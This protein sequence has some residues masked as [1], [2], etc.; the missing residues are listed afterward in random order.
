VINLR[1]KP[2]APDALRL[3]HITTV[4]ETLSF[5]TGQVGY[6]QSQGFEVF[7]ISSPGARLQ[8]FAA[9]E[10]VTC[11]A[12]AMTRR[13]SPLDDLRSLLKM[14][15]ELRRIRPAI[16]HGHTPKGGL[17][18]MIAAWAAGV[19]VRIYHVH[20]LPLTT[21]TGLKRKLLC[22]T[23]R[24][25]CFFSHQVLCV[26]RSVRDVAIQER[27]CP[28]GKIKVLAQ[29]T[30]NGID[31]QQRFDPQRLGPDSGVQFRRHYGIPADARL[32]GFVGRIVRDKGLVELCA[33]WRELRQQFADVHLLIAGPFESQDPVPPD[34]EHTLR[35]DNRV[36]LPG[37]VADMPALYSAVDVILLPTYRE[38]F[39]YVP[40]EAA[41]MGIPVVATR[42]PGCMEAVEE[43]VT[44]TL[45][46]P[47]DAAALA[48][49]AR[50]YLADADLRR[51]HGAAGRQRMLREFQQET[52]WSAI[53]Q[54]Y[55]RWLGLRGLA[56]EIGRRATLL[57]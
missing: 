41:A 8:A 35:T 11:R 53:Y 55:R 42:V 48:E 30:I 7:A 18:G 5:L 21:A 31:A 3:V 4:P 16:V 39:P 19:P 28:P 27:L 15:R 20:G 25:S 57:V 17:L 12:V 46:A 26:S 47:R 40:L 45:V 13:I 14:W 9:Q 2:D 6:M 38:G 36:H 37:E 29:G 34:V 52:V 1:G 33:A 10:H 43:G 23:E 32:L 24:L 44:G 22:W 54:E 49:A 51:R 50:R 56:D